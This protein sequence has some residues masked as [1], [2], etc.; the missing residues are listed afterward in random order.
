MAS[1]PVGP[2]NLSE[3]FL[4][5]GGPNSGER[6]RTDGRYRQC[7]YKSLQ[8]NYALCSASGQLHSMKGAISAWPRMYSRWYLP[9]SRREALSF[10]PPTGGTIDGLTARAYKPPSQSR[11][12]LM[13]NTTPGIER[14]S[15]SRVGR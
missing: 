4:A 12:D 5:M 15:H 9:R 13:R 11:E 3:N 10:L 8:A 6:V 14:E 2:R 1:S 7:C